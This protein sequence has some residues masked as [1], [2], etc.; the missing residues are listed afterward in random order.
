MKCAPLM[1]QVPSALSLVTAQ[2]KAER[3]ARLASRPLGKAH[4]DVDGFYY[5]EF[6]KCHTNAGIRWC[7]D[8]GNKA[9]RG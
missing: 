5:C 3:E 6:C 2:V 8:E 4:R 1:V 9:D 7:C